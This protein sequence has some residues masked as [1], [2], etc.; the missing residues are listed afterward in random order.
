MDAIFVQGLMLL[1]LILFLVF[2]NSKK[3]KKWME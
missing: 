3:G 1:A 2:A